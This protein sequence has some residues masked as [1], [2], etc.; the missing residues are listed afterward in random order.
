MNFFMFLNGTQEGY[1]GRCDLVLAFLVRLAISLAVLL[2]EDP[3][4]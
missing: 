3:L 4:S 2:R 1:E